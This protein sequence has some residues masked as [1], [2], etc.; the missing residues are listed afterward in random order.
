M[1]DYSHHVKDSFWTDVRKSKI[2]NNGIP[3]ALL[4]E[5]IDFS[6]GAKQKKTHKPEDEWKI[7]FKDEGKN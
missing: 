1:I 6:H 3:F 4:R 7:I 5:G 2:S